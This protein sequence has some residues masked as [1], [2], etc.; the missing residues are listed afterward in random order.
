MS[1]ITPETLKKFSDKFPEDETLLQ[2]YCDAAE[3]IIEEYLGY[4]PELKEYETSERGI[5]S[6]YFALEAK[7][8]VEVTAITADSENVDLSRVKIVKGT[9]YIAFDDDSFFARGVKYAVQYSAGFETIPAPIVTAGLQIASLLWESAGGNVS[10][11]STSFIDSAS[12]TFQ[13]FKPE[14]FL[15]PNIGKYKLVKVDY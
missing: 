14:R 7:P 2:N 3:Q 1:Y 15:E 5:G 4:S 9:N 10:V 13:S 6:L 8:V 12:R 11:T